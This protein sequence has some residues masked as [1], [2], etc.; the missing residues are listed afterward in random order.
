MSADIH[1]HETNASEGICPQDPVPPSRSAREVW[2]EWTALGARASARRRRTRLCGWLVLA[3]TTV[4]IPVAN[5]AEARSFVQREADIALQQPGPHD[6]AGVTTAFPF[7]EHEPGLDFVYRKRILHRG[8][9]IGVHR[10]DKDEIYHVLS[11]RGELTL[12]GE[13]SMVGP[14]DAVLTRNGHTHGLEQRGEEDLVILVVYP[15]PSR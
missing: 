3:G 8:A 9:S 15:Q 10:N 11:G 6:G 4:A 7:F 12:E 14:G 1:L 13:R 2:P 5:A